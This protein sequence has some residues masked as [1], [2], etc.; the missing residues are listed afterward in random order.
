MNKKSLRKIEKEELDTF[1]YLASE[2]ALK[3]IW[4][5][6]KDEEVWSKY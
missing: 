6:P 2:S 3:K 4:D 1:V 5:N